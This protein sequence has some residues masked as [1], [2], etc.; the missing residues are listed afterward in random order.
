MSSTLDYILTCKETAIAGVECEENGEK[1]VWND[2]CCPNIIIT[3]CTYLSCIFGGVTVLI[4]M[5]IG[6][7]SALPAIIIFLSSFG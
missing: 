2:V 6:G 5:L 4:W 1:V 7:N 3:I